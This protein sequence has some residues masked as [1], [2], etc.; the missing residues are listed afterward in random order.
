MYFS[1]MH[2]GIS[3]SNDLKRV[4][5]LDDLGIGVHALLFGLAGAEAEADARV[6]RIDRQT[7]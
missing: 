6:G 5:E 2:R 4:S 1:P 3:A 7:A